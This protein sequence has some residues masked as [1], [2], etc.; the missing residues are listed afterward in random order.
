M[1]LTNKPEGA[2]LSFR[3]IP[4]IDG[5]LVTTQDE[6]HGLIVESE[7]LKACFRTIRSSPHT[8]KENSDKTAE[9]HFKGISQRA[10]S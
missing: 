4:S 7:S 1:F 9:I 8:S 6:L 5:P 3:R 10:Q 2:W